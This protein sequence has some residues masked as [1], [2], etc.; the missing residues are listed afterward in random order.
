MSAKMTAKPSTDTSILRL[1]LPKGR[2]A[3][4]VEAL[5]AE[6]GIR[7]TQTSRGYRPAISFDGVDAKVLKPQSIVEMLRTG[8]RDVGFTGADWVG[9]LDADLVELLDTGLD[10][11]RVVAAAPTALLER[12]ALPKRALLVATEYV[13]LTARWIEAEGLDAQVVR[14][15]GATEVYPP[16]DADLIVD[17]TA[18]GSTLRANQLEIQA[19]LLRSSTRLYAAPSALRDPRKRA[20][21][22]DLVVL[23]ESVLEA[24]RRA[25]VELNVT[26]A[27]LAAVLEALPCMRTPTVSPLA[28]AAGW[29]VRAAVPRDRL[30]DVLAGLR[31]RGG[32]DIVVSRPEQI[33]A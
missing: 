21:I 33:L 31:A 2:M 14:S 16:E 13:Q 7:V 19:E 29:A 17:N 22:E 28:G 12:G 9:E 26:D 27:Q 6:C 30:P 23:L 18:T 24:R 20:R 15:Y 8:S 3:Q 10:P 5:L 1:A 25:L 11:V 4:G 32:T